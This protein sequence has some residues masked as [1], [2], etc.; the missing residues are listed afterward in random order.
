MYRRA[1][2]WINVAKR[3]HVMLMAKLRS[4]RMLIRTAA[5]RLGSEVSG[6][7]DG[8]RRVPSENPESCCDI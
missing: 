8:G 7:E 1:H 2:C 4:H 6:G 5:A 3:A